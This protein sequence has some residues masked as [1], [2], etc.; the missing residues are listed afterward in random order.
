MVIVGRVEARRA[1]YQDYQAQN[2]CKYIKGPHTLR[3]T[4]EDTK[5]LVCRLVVEG[6]RTIC[7]DYPAQIKC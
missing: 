7:Q 1:I 6:R 5:F 3:P 4:F 2:K